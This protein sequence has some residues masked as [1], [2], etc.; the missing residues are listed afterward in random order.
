MFAQPSWIRRLQSG[1]RHRRTARGIRQGATRRRTAQRPGL[2]HLEDRRVLSYSVTNLGSLGGTFSI[3]LSMNSRGAVVGVSY[4]ANDAAEHA[5]IAMHG[6][7]T[8]L[9]TL[10]GS[11]AE[12]LGIDDQ[13]AVV[14]VSTAAANNAQPEI[15]LYKHGSMTSI[16]TLNTG[17]NTGGNIAINDHGSIIGFTLANGDAAIQQHGKLIDLGSLGGQ[18]SGALALNAKGQV[19]GYSVTSGTGSATITHAFLYNHGK[20]T[21]LGTLG[22]TFAEADSIN[23]HGAAVGISY[24]TSGASHA[25]LFSH[26]AMADIGTLGG[27]SAAAAAINDSG[28]VVGSSQ[29]SNS[30][31]HAFLYNHGVMTDLNTLIPA[32]S[33]LTIIS[34]TAINDKGQI[35]A[36][37][38]STNPQ[39]STVYAVLLNP[40][41]GKARAPRARIEPTQ[42]DPK[43]ERGIFP[44]MIADAS[45][46][47]RLGL[48]QNALIAPFR[49]RSAV[50]DPI[51]D[52]AR[53]L[54]SPSIDRSIVGAIEGNRT[55]AAAGSSS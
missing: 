25:F 43:P 34:A 10:G 1:L 50:S 35:A 48:K 26:G 12:A 49:R 30:V 37:A 9:G 13:G 16:G 44:R 7:T 54:A 45:G 32:D 20:M 22:G 27:S 36:E 19:V 29:T 15:F 8:D 11:S 47:Y 18:G 41:K 3:P 31:Q 39:D 6:V 24:T 38:V 5:F 21:D 52:R 51:R 46:W 40:S 55:V 42:T 53:W 33:G 4:T 23:I 28:A 2:E 14:G 17:L